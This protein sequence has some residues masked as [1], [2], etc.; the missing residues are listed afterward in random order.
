MLKLHKMKA[1]PIVMIIALLAGSLYIGSAQ[2]AT[3]TSLSTTMTNQTISEATDHTILFTTPT[4]V[5]AGETI[6]LTFAS[7]SGTGASIAAALDFEDLDLSYDEAGGDGVCD[8]GDTELTLAGAASTTTWG[9]VRTSGTVITFTSDSGTIPAGAEIC[10]EIGT[11]AEAGATG[12]EQVTNPDTASA[13]HTIAIAGTQT[14]SGSLAYPVIT[15]DTVTVT[16]TVDPTIT[17]AIRNSDDN[18]DTN[19]CSLGTLST[20]SVSNCAYRLAVDTNASGGYTIYFAADA[21]LNNASS[22]TIDDI[23][24]DGTVSSGTEGYGV[25]VTGATAGGAS[26]ATYTEEGIFNDDD[27]PIPTTTTALFSI[28]K[29]ADYTVSSLTTSTLVTHK[30]AISAVTPAGA[31]NQAVTYTVVGAF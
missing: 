7:S 20:G 3:L 18:G 15:N 19:A 26:G 12:A 29:P 2:A 1:L 6:T 13:N 5:A 21:T 9:A 17:F 31:Y 28:N 10:V 11:G 22:D 24:E 23:A 4:G 8:T 16:A 30:A 14:D 27:S 25:A